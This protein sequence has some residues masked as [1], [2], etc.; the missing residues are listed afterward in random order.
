MVEKESLKLTNEESKDII[1]YILSIFKTK[2]EMKLLGNMKEKGDSWKICNTRFLKDKLKE[3]LNLNHYVDVANYCLML[4]YLQ[5]LEHSK[6][7]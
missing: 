2:M 7:E 3:H 1:K 6:K 4:D 5:V